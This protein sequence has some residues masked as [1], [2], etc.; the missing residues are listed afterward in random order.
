MGLYFI[1][2]RMLSFVTVGF[3]GKCTLVDLI[4]MFNYADDLTTT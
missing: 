2:L 3:I 4:R 1:L